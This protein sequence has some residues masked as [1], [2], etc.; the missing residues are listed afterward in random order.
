M[1]EQPTFPFLLKKFL[2]QQL[3]PHSELSFLEALEASYLEIDGNIRTFNSAVATFRA[4]SD[5]SGIYGM[6]REHIRATTSWRGGPARY[7]CILINSDPNVEGAL[8]F[9][10]AR[11]FLFF[12]FQHQGKTYPCALVQWYS[13]MGEEPDEDTGFWI[14]EPD[15]D[16]DGSPHLGIVHVDTI[17]RAVH[18]MPAYNTA[19]FIDKT[20]T[21]HSSLD[22]FHRFYVNKFIDHHIFATLSESSSTPAA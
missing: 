22:S 7:D 6:R 2:Y 1:L 12:S 19:E 15:A 14:I 11:T 16:D 9:E 13:Y 3:Y 17:Y 21:M 4:P 5:T 8:G 10:V 20:I 18:L